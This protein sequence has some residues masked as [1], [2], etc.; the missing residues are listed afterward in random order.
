MI[1]ASASGGHSSYSLN[2]WIYDPVKLYLRKTFLILI[3]ADIFLLLLIGIGYHYV[4]WVNDYFSSHWRD[5]YL[6][7]I[8][9][10]GLPVLILAFFIFI[11]DHGVQL[12]SDRIKLVIHYQDEVFFLGEVKEFYAAPNPLR[13]NVYVISFKQK[14]NRHCF[15][16]KLRT[17]AEKEIYQQLLKEWRLRGYLS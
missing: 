12:G 13:K 9:L 14:D 15:Y 16:F 1:R 11:S 8:S 17:Q 7:V 4:S 6:L 2:T 10:S 3:G 5:A